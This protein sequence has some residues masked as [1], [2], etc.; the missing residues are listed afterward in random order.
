MTKS[1]RVLLVCDIEENGNMSKFARN[2]GVTPSYI[3]KLK[4]RPDAD[5]SDIFIREV[6]RKYGIN[7]KW[8]LY[9]EGEIKLP[10]T[11]EQEIANITAA[12][13]N[14]DPDGIQYKFMKAI[15]GLS[16]EQ[17]K[18]IQDFINKLSE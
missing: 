4:S 6:S 11:R 18:D 8:L 2:T 5:P 9:G 7:E 14:A 12:L 16:L 10:L 3:S 17:W 15:A 13:Y 1:E